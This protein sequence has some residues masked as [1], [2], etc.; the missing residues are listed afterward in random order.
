LGRATET[1]KL[2]Q[3]RCDAALQIYLQQQAK[4][5]LKPAPEGLE[6]AFL[7]IYDKK[8]QIK[9]FK[10]LTL[11]IFTELFFRKEC[12]GRCNSIFGLEESA[13]RYMLNSVRDTRNKLAHFREDEIT[14]PMRKQLRSCADWLNRHRG[15]AQETF[16]KAAAVEQQPTAQTAKEAGTIPLVE[17]V[18]AAQGE[19]Q[20]H[21]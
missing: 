12:W 16:E 7:E 10:E 5:S 21:S 11:E 18:D 2:L 3:E 15:A 20:G 6:D 8:E 9:P 19:P 4:S 17:E 13:A 1:A 14:A